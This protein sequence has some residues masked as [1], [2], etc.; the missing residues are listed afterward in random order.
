LSYLKKQT[1]S[2][3]TTLSTLHWFFQK[4][5]SLCNC[6]QGWLQPA[7]N[8]LWD[9]VYYVL[10]MHMAILCEQEEVNIHQQW[11]VLIALIH[12]YV[13]IDYAIHTSRYSWVHIIFT[14]G[15]SIIALVFLPY[16][17]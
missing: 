12:T 14:Y 15:R 2:M 8:F 6:W 17:T 11:L 3:R 4:F 13:D 9:C 16:D 5:G 7:V 1:A 10:P